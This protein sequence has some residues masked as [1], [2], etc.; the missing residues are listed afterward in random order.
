MGQPVIFER[1]PTQWV[2]PNCP[3]VARTPWDCPNRMH[4]CPGLK[5]MLAPMLPRGVRASVVAVEREDYVGSEDV[6]LDGDGRPVMSVITTR[7]DGQDCIVFAPTARARG[8]R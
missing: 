5:G 1:P 4:A 6:R 7:D 3:A 8:D 2:C